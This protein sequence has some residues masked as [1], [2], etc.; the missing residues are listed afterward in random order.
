M[1]TTIFHN[2]G[3]V[4]VKLVPGH[5]RNAE[6]SYRDGCEVLF[7]R[8]HAWLFHNGYIRGAVIDLGAWIGDNTLPW[9]FLTC[10]TIYAIDPSPA[11][12]EYVR[13]LAAANQR[14]NI[15]VLEHAISDRDEEL[16]TTDMLDHCS[17]V[18][19][20]SPSGNA[21]QATSLDALLARGVLTGVDYIHLDVEGMEHKVL[22]GAS[23]L[24]K[25]YRPMVSFEQHIDTENWQSIVD[26]FDGYEVYRIEEVMPHC[27]HDCRNFLAIPWERGPWAVAAV[28]S[29]LTCVTRRS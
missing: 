8:I 23:S 24:L 25:Q 29:Q 1:D 6:F 26:M 21:V 14:S 19:N 22:V 5:S 13:A 12:C 11:N 17:F 4:V 10:H 2:D 3:G 7:R 20:T 18:W 27:R 16:R 9:S 15:V 28:W